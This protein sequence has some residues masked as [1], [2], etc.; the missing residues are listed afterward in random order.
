[1]L[2]S[3]PLARAARAGIFAAVAWCVLQACAGPE[4]DPGTGA[5][6]DEESV[7]SQVE[8]GVWAFH[9]ADTARSAEQVIA[10]L[11]PEFEMLVDGQ[12]V[13]FDEVAE[14]SRTFMAGVE[15]FHTTWSDLRIIPL[16]PDAAVS[17]FI[18]RDSIVTRSGELIRNRGPTTLVWQRRDGE[19]RIRFGDA[20]HYP[21]DR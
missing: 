19:W 6:Y 2:R 9:R 3:R 5:Q 16:G 8:A 12:R 1:M 11:W 15:T 14:G 21:I 20:D 13:G 4:A 10:L 17:S 7:R 18:F